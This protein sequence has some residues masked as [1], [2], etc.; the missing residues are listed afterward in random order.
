MPSELHLWLLTVLPVFSQPQCVSPT[1][2]HAVF[3]TSADAY[4]SKYYGPGLKGPTNLLVC[5]RNGTSSCCLA[6]DTCLT[7]NTCYNYEVG[8]LYQ[9][10]CTDPSYTADSCP[11]KCGWNY[12]RSPW[13]A[14]E[15]C[16]DVSGVQGV[17]ACHSPESCY[18]E[19]KKSFG[20]LQLSPIGCKEM[21]DKA[22]VALFAPSALQP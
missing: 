17:W 16:V 2:L 19:W 6:G 1:E 4:S 14:L 21:G 9:Y 5:G 3:R 11:Y 13:T 20:L 8:D 15:Y 12:T 22:R 7:G 18:C 10:G